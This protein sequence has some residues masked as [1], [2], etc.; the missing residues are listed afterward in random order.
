MTAYTY[1][2]W[3]HCLN[4]LT[5]YLTQWIRGQSERLSRRKS[6]ETEQWSGEVGAFSLGYGRFE[7]L[8]VFASTILAQLGAMFIVK[9]S[10]ER[11]V[12]APEIHT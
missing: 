2:S 8:A 12:E 9:E 3:F 1:V 4:L 11:V 10:L 6:Q 7:V 5:C